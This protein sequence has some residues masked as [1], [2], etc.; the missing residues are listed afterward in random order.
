MVA[1]PPAL[2][3]QLHLGVGACLDLRID[4]GRLVLEPQRRPRYSLAE[5]IARC[6]ADAPRSAEDEAWLT[7]PAVGREA[8]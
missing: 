3:D 1:L 2:L 7:T 6:D 5:L 8:L 4:G